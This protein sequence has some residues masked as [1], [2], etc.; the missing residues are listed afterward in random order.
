MLIIDADMIMRTPFVPQAC[1]CR[2]ACML[3][4]ACCLGRR[5][6]LR[7]WPETGSERDEHSWLT[8]RLPC[9][10]DAGAKPGWAVSAFFGYMKGVKNQLAMKHIPEVRSEQMHWALD[11]GG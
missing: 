5:V 4:P 9:L 8:P 7:A 6:L 11:M 10:Q 1:C 2:V 3:L